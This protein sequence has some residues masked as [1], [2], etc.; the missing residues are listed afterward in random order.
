[1]QE[2]KKF[3]LIGAVLAVIAVFVLLIY[4]GIFWWTMLGLLVLIVVLLHF[5]LSIHLKASR[6]EGIDITAK[7]MFLTVYPR[8]EKPAGKH[9][10]PD[11]IQPPDEPD[12]FDPDELDD[13]DDGVTGEN[14][15]EDGAGLGELVN[16]AAKIDKEE[17]GK[18][19]E[20]P[21][22][23]KKAKP[24]PAPKSEKGE[25]GIAKL[26]RLYAKVKPYIPIGWKA[27]KKFCKAIRFEDV[28]VRAEVGRF[29]AHEAAIYYGAVQKIVFDVL[30]KI[31]LFF[32]L[33]LKRADVRCAFGENKLDGSAELT[34]RV[35][36]ST[37]IAIAF[38][39]GVKLLITFLR[40]RRKKKKAGKEQTAPVQAV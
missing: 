16:E 18:P 30:S 9:K 17:E 21:R 10:A 19:P 3:K 35:R 38:C 20:P 14:T 5:S 31:G 26:K 33:K 6:A 32:T 7:Y 36:P 29:D 39:T 40:E 24:E 27:V 13:L 37:L 23:N 4:F 34:V 1:M 2:I 8:R 11:G 22:K 25:G 15:E 28:D 12:P